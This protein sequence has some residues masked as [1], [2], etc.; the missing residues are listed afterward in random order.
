MQQQWTISRLNCNVWWKVDFIPQ[1]G[2]TISVAGPR[3]SSKA[4]PKAKLA[5]KKVMV[6]GGL[7]LVWSTTAFWILVNPLHLRIMLSKL[8]MCTGNCSA[9]IRHW[10]TERAQFFSMTMPDYMAHNQQFKSWMNW[11][12][13]FHLIC[14]V[15]LPVASWLP[16]LQASWQL[17]AG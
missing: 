4:L 2:M 8:M 13:K 1:P 16:L 6:T 17:F 5:P 12:T 11:V 3:G 15:H 10:S 14:Y 9:F 7:L